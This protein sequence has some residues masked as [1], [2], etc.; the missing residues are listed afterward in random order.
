MEKSTAASREEAQAQ[1][2]AAIDQHAPLPGLDARDTAAMHL[3]LDPAFKG[4]RVGTLIYGLGDMLVT[5]H[6]GK[7]NMYLIDGLDAQRI[8]NAARNIEIAMWL[9]AR[10]QDAAGRP[11][12]LSNALSEHDRNLSFERMFGSMIGRL[13]LLA[14]FTAEK[15]RRAVIDYAQS[16]FGGQFLQ[17]LPVGAAAGALSS[18]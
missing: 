16:L 3:A 4:D 14:E 13:D 7:R 12:L 8:Y 10:R 15:Y 18:Q 9:L 5:A 17:F 11:L 2:R 1:I 6:G